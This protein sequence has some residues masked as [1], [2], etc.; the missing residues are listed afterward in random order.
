MNPEEALLSLVWLIKNGFVFPQDPATGKP[1][2]VIPD[3]AQRF[4][5]IEGKRL[6][7]KQPVNQL[8]TILDVE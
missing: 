4:N 5:G 2:V 6:I 8:I 3:T 1:M 7:V